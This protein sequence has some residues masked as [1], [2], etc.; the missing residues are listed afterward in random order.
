MY[1]R[2]VRI[3]FTMAASNEFPRLRRIQIQFSWNLVHHS[4][5]YTA[6]TFI[7]PAASFFLTAFSSFHLYGREMEHGPLS[8][9][10]C[11]TNQTQP[12]QMMQNLT[13]VLYKMEISWNTVFKKMKAH[14]NER[15]R[16][17]YFYRFDR[18]WFFYFLR[19][20]V[21]I[22]SACSD[23]ICPWMICLWNEP[24]S[25]PQMFIEAQTEK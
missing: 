15:D 7:K 12:V 8:T 11:N 25:L 16:F 14:K 1:V 10:N 13:H 23:G 22:H 17:Q 19:T 3:S 6:L 18:N 2:H 20:D 21:Q 24:A 9:E 4:I 5:H